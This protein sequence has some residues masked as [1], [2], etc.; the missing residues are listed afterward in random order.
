MQDGGQ[1]R[2]YNGD[3]LRTAYLNPAMTSSTPMVWL[4]Q[5]SAGASKSEIREN[6]KAELKATDQGAW[7]DDSGRVKWSVDDIDQVPIWKEKVPY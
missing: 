1:E 2:S 4:A 5:D 3:D 7:L 6:E